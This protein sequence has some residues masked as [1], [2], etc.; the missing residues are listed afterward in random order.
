MKCAF[1]IPVYNHG[2]TLEDVVSRL[3]QYNLPVIVVDDGNDALNKNL[4]SQ[5][6]QKHADAVIIVN[7]TKNGGKGRAMNDG[8]R[9]ADELGFTHVF[10]IDADGQ[11]DSDVCSLFLQE[12]EKTPD[13]VICGFPEYDDSVPEKR[14]KGREFSNIWARFV[15]LNKDIKDVL[16]GF[17]IYPV[18]PYVELLHHHA[19][20]NSHMGYD[21]DILVHLSWK[22][23]K[24]RSFSVPVTY[25]KDGVSNFR[26]VRDNIHISLT[27]ARL[28]IG[29]LFRLPVLVFRRIV[30]KES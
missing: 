19:I 14:R 11:H 22:G 7:R 12:A 25:P 24:I 13:A 16:C 30:K 26:M 15:T 10:Q 1:V 28:C 2:A 6:V 4:I 23:L 21:T 3:L 9:K 17:R 29:M 20:I 5:V 27:Y 8:V 18:K